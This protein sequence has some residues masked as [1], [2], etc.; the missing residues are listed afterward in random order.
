MTFWLTEGRADGTTK[1]WHVDCRVVGPRL[2]NLFLPWCL[3]IQIVSALS[4]ICPELY[5]SDC[6]RSELSELFLPFTV[7]IQIVAALDCLSCFCPELYFFR[8]SPLWII[9]VVFALIFIYS[10]CLCSGLSELN[11]S[12]ASRHQTGKHLVRTW[13]VNASY[14][15]SIVLI[16][17]IF[18]LIVLILIIAILIAYILIIR[19]LINLVQIFLVLII[20][21]L[22]IN[23]LIMNILIILILIIL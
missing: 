20:L 16:L 19:I 7:S 11:K 23:I 12:Y 9:W 17:N 2:K 15:Y 6:L 5:Y 1:K 8:L 3:F 18:I 22:L 10:D 13:Q 21:V 14:P 4:C